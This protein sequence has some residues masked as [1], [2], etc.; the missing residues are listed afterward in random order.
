MKTWIILFLVLLAAGVALGL[1]RDLFSQQKRVL[2]GTVIGV[3][4]GNSQP[5][6][7]PATPPRYTVRLS[8]GA[9]VDVATRNPHSVPVGG[10]IPITEWMTPWG[11]VWYTQR[12]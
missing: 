5:K 6:W 2:T 11:Q 10:H 12:D 4:L 9:I 7:F 3:D 8:D 1:A